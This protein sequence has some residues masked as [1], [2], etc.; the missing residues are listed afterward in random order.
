M[1]HV[2]RSGANFVLFQSVVCNILL[3]CVVSVL[4]LRLVVAAP[5]TNGERVVLEPVAELWDP[6]GEFTA[7]ARDNRFG[8]GVVEWNS[9][10]FI[11]SSWRP[12]SSGQA[13]GCIDIFDASTPPRLIR[14]VYPSDDAPFGGALFQY[15]SWVFADLL[16]SPGRLLAYEPHFRDSQLQLRTDVTPENKI[17][18]RLGLGAALEIPSR[19]GAWGLATVNRFCR[20]VA[21]SDATVYQIE[22]DRRTISAFKFN[23]DR[24]E[25]GREQ[26]YELPD[27]GVD[28]SIAAGERLFAVGSPTANVDGQPQGAVYVFKQK[29]TNNPVLV[30][31]AQTDA[32]QVWFGQDVAITDDRLFVL[33]AGASDGS[34]VLVPSSITIYKLDSLAGGVRQPESQYNLP[35]GH[36]G[37]RLTVT[38]RGLALT[39]TSLLGKGSHSIPSFYRVVLLRIARTPGA[40]VAARHNLPLNTLPLPAGVFVRAPRAASGPSVTPP[41]PAPQTPSPASAS[42]GIDYRGNCGFANLGRLAYVKNYSPDKRIHAIVE[43]S[44]W[45]LTERQSTRSGYSLAAGQEKELTCSYGAAVGGPEYSFNIVYANYE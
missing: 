20:T 14:T 11:S 28:L 37:R 25:F 43:K 13:K 40:S 3:A 38:R 5:A 9:L 33:A 27:S 16:G 30:L 35:A 42:V 39:V 21:A 45:N 8:E 36:I 17:E 12:N 24:R 7:D 22:R 44:W 4:S 32:R 18:G 31:D 10:V 6:A 23:A 34:R 15:G 41:G 26:T 1:P 19:Y 2:F 29:S